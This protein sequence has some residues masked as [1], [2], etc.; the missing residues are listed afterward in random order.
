M[1]MQQFGLCSIRLVQIITCTIL[2]TLFV[3]PVIAEEQYGRYRAIVLHDGGQSTKSGN[4]IPK[5]FIMDSQEGHMWVLDQN[6]KLNNPN[7]HFSLGTV[8]T[9]QGQVRPGK[10][11]GEIVEQAATLR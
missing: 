5:V 3:A 6:T 8:L 2:G 1:M 9:Y 10:K 11:M 4:L 7:G